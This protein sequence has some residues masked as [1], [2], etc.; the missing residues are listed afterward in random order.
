[1]ERGLLRGGARASVYFTLAVDSGSFPEVEEEESDQAA[2]TTPRTRPTG[3]FSPDE[4]LAQIEE[5][6]VRVI[7]TLNE[8]LTKEAVER[9]GL[10]DTWPFSAGRSDLA[11]TR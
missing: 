5:V 8:A 7:E 1:M 11:I 2:I 3:T 4:D 6:K 9:G 10:A